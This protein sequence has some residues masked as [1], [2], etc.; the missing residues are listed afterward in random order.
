MGNCSTQTI[1]IPMSTFKSNSWVATCRIKNYNMPANKWESFYPL[2]IL[3]HVKQ[4]SNKSVTSSAIRVKTEHISIIK[5]KLCNCQTI[6]CC[7]FSHSTPV[8][9]G[10]RKF[11]I[12]YD[13]KTVSTQA[14]S[15]RK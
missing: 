4:G 14:H 13:I 7:P 15:H 10:H 6:W 11:I 8:T 3:F 9:Q 5:E 1:V 2:D 12:Y